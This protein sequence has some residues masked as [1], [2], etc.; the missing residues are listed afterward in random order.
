[1]FIG[2]FAVGLGA[3]AAS[4]KTSL[5]SLF[6][7]AQFLDLVWPTLLL[8]G[9][10][11]VEISPGITKMTPLDFTYYPFTHS[12]LMA[13]VWGLLFGLV[14]W[15]LRKNRKAALVLGLCVVSHWLLDLVVHRPDLPLIP[16]DSIKVGLG[17]WNSPAGT[18][19]VEGII[20]TLGLWLYLR[21][22]RARNKAG[23]YGFWGLIIFLIAI[24]FSNFFGPPPPSVAAIAWAGHLQWLFVIWGYWVD[25]NREVRLSLA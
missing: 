15:L 11:S 18:L 19:I 5:G 13:T 3:K 24:Y 21:T 16:G 6:L 8:L 14:Y 9:V 12:L 22:T 17:L 10:E 4:P 2:H 7:A 1:M 20:F 25:K 23:M